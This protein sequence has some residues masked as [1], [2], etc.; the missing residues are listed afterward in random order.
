MAT[1]HYAR[2]T[3]LVAK[4]NAGDY[5]DDASP[6]A[7]TDA[8]LV[9]NLQVTPYEAETATRQIVQPYM[10]G[11]HRITWGAVVR[12]TFN[13][14]LQGSGDPDVA[15][16][17]ATLLRG[18]GFAQTTR[19][20]AAAT[21]GDLVP[22][23]TPDGTVTIAKT[24]A[25]AG[26]VPRT[27]TLE[28]TKAGGS[29]TAEFS[30]TAP[31]IGP[32]AAHSAT[33][34]VMTDSTPFDLVGGAQITPTIGT[35]FVMGD[36]FTID[37]IPERVEYNPVSTGHS[38]LT[39][40][41]YLDGIEHRLVGAMGEASLTIEPGLPTLQFNFLGL[42]IDPDAVALPNDEDF[43]AWVQPDPAVP[44]TVIIA[45]LHGWDMRLARLQLQMGNQ[46]TA[47]RLVN[48][49]A[50]QITDRDV[51]GSVDCELDSLSAFDP[52]GA[53]RG[54][55]LGPLRL[56][57]GATSGRVVSIAAPA[58]QILSPRYEERDSIMHLVADL[59]AIPAAGNDELIIYTA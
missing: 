36:K 50:I 59:A 12:C 30:V 22:V 5:G 13:V 54:N 1:R 52:F 6:A 44:D 38:D 58:V 14:E 23:G 15:P 16:P 37:V 35:S 29:G 27:V 25:Y 42:Y 40:V 56:Q 26:A 39:L 24:T 28:C 43:S 10:G 20:G 31:P 11:R 53:A 21:I 4:L 51:T 48:H 9:S 8:M 49:H 7:S 45:Q 46:V 2:N 33:D 3:L 19:S 41:Y 17:W 32:L 47:R 55:L 57:H 34:K 18:C